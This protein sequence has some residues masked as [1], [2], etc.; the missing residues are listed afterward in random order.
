MD[1]LASDL[2]ECFKFHFWEGDPASLF[3]AL[4]GVRQMCV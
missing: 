1:K 3:K 4:A 2:V